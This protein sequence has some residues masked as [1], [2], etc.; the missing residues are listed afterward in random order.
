MT[1]TNTNKNASRSRAHEMQRSLVRRAAT[2]NDGD[3]DFTHE[4][5]EVERFDGL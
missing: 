5:L 3:V 2:D 1:R 4:L